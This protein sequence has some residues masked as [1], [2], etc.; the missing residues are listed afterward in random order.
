MRGSVAPLARRGGT[1]HIAD[2]TIDPNSD[3]TGSPFLRP[4]G[5]LAYAAAQAARVAW[6]FGQYMLVARLTGPAVPADRRPAGATHPDRRA[7]LA[8]LRRLMERDLANIRAGRYRLPHDLVPDPGRALGNAAAFLR[9]VPE[10]TR[11][12]RGRIAAEVRERPP[13]GSERLPAYYRQNF[14]FQ[15][16]GYLSER[17]AR[18]YDHQV[19]VL[20]GGG[21]DAMRRQ[22]LV[23][24]FEH[25]RDRRVA[26]CRLLDVAAGT[27]G[28]LT[29]VKDNWP[30]LPVLGVDLSHAYLTEARRRLLPW[31]RS[32]ALVQ[33]AAESLPVA[34][35]SQDVVTCVYLFH[36]L[37]PRLR[38][39]VAA[40]F[41]RVLKPG[42]IL[43]FVDSLQ[44]GDDPAMDGLLATFPVAFHEPYFEHYTGDDLT[45]LFAAAGLTHRS[46]TTA[47][48]SKVMVFARPPAG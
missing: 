12:R 41:A 26:D 32:A 20:F 1:F 45:G 9:D 42:G 24:L 25:L 34:G 21:A 3:R 23:P 10:V 40:E 36:E 18:L 47:F 2:M 37:P 15:T 5:R 35:A 8:A 14:H 17:S 46:T 33:A 27:G 38:R 39:V 6:F 30:R 44:R 19:E 28:F 16:D 4:S 22:A 7:I 29:M 31:T 48:L 11:R 13:A 43:I